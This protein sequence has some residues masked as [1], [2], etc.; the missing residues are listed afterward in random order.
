MRIAIFVGLVCAAGALSG[1][2]SANYGTAT[3]PGSTVNFVSSNP[4]GV[5][6]DF[7]ARPPGELTAA[8]DIASQQCHMFNRGYAKPESFNTRAE[9][10]IRGTY[11]CGK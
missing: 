1:C 7:G 11:R 4:D 6:L 9:G 2:G 10:T 3:A 5:L 8:N